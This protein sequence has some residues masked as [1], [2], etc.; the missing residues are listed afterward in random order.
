MD[1]FY[2][3]FSNDMWRIMGKVF[4][5]DPLH[6]V[7]TD[8][9]VFLKDN[10]ID[11]LND[12]GIGLFDTACEVRRLQDNA[13]DKFLDVVKQTDIEALLSQMPHCR[14]IVTTGQKATDTICERF[15]INQPKMGS[16]TEFH[17]N[18]TCKDT[19]SPFHLFR[20]PSSSR[21]YP[22][23]LQKKAEAYYSMFKNIGI[24]S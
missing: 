22:L 5:D 6:F 3:N 11:F 7:D 14:N 21:A 24:I 16:F 20:M 2:P 17:I 12:R 10:I 8:R 19:S 15:G 18:S 23:S 4:Y 9:K 1:F 13:S